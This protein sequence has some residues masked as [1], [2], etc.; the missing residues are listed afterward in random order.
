M[1]K[2]DTIR[3]FA[4]SHV[5]DPYIF[6]ASGQKCTPTFRQQQIKSKPAYAANIKKYCPVLS[7]KQATCEG[8]KYNN[9]PSH[10]CSGMTMEA[11]ALVGI[12]VP[13][14]ASS[15]WKGDYWDEKGTIDKMPKD[16]VCF[17]FNETDSADPMGHVGI[18]LGDGYVV[19]ARGHAQGVVYGKLE[20]YAWDHYGI[21]KGMKNEE[22]TDMPTIP[23]PHADG[24]PTLSRGADDTMFTGPYVSA[25]QD[26]LV[27]R[28]CTL[29]KYGVDGDF[30]TETEAAV[31]AFQ[32]LK[33]LSADGICG[34]LTW[35]ALL[36]EPAPSDPVATYTFVVP[37]ITSAQAMAECDY[38]RAIYGACEMAVG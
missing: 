20:S 7:G 38:L 1:N 21:L 26:L 17:V 2:A 28:G 33:G 29:P 31:K 37:G 5:G 4:R 3:N 22:V 14:G 34:P 19:D 27:K 24:R 30:G 12:K 35:A 11:A 10:D 6:A 13:H 23:A 18:Y 16:K 32:Q 15:L 36:K 9:K 25:M 8:C